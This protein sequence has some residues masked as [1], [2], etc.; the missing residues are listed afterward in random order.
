LT[1]RRG[2]I[3][4]WEKS[5][6]RQ[7]ADLERPFAGRRPEDA[8]VGRARLQQFIRRWIRQA[9]GQA[10]LLVGVLLIG[11][12]LAQ[13][14]A[15]MWPELPWWSV[16]VPTVLWLLTLVTAVP[17]LLSTVFKLRAAAVL[18]AFLA[19]S[20][21]E[22]DF[23]ARRAA[24]VAALLRRGLTTLALGLMLWALVIRPPWPAAA[25]LAAAFVA[26]TV[27]LARWHARF[28]AANRR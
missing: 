18:H 20:A 6:T 24:L 3:A 23:A 9:V 13:H 27:S 28:H 25:A 15:P 7:H 11:G 14:F 1:P 21:D 12:F 5:V 8:L 16:V 26:I 10:I 22:E 2:G 4:R 19:V 17:L